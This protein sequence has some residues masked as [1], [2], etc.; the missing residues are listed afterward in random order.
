VG[1]ALGVR[2]AWCIHAART[3]AIGDP[4]AYYY[5]GVQIAHGEGYTSY[6]QAFQ[7]LAELTSG[8]DLGI[9][10][11]PVPSALY[12]PG[13]P[14]VLGALFWLVLHSPL[15]EG[16]IAAAAALNIALSTATLVLAFSI[17][18]R[19]FDARVALVAAALLAVY[20][21]L[22][23][24]NG[25]L[26]WETTFIFLVMAALWVLVARPWSER[27][28]PV[29]RLLL[30][31]VLLGGSVLIRPMS[32]G[33]V[34]ALLVASRAAGVPWRRVFAQ[35][36]IVVAIVGLMLVPWTVR[37]VIKMDAPV[38]VSTEVG[39][40][41]CVSRQPGARGNKDYTRMEKYCL[42]STKGVPFDEWEVRENNY[43]MARARDFV[44]E[45]PLQELRLWAP[46]VR[47]AYRTDHDSLDD[48]YTT[49]ISL[50]RTLGR[51]ADRYYYCVLALAA[52]GLPALLRRPPRLLLLVTT[53]SLAITPILLFGAPRYKVPVTPFFTMIAAVGIVTVADFIHARVGGSRSRL[54]R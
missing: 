29:R 46:R 35:C 18:R 25:T 53:A 10:N 3:P 36:A 12:P 40:A 41:L 30:F 11:D 44:V 15:P 26:H 4:P 2:V 27:G 49:S 5:Y 20:P 28:V 21:N 8:R 39:A 14:A 34:P 33:L 1:V 37:N 9:P 13:Y 31:S 16:Y 7:Q 23:F 32:L 48:A 19:L 52:L 42:P 47:Y 45:H 6:Y 22:V 50:R 51:V 38:V 24:Y 17:V 54:P 43:G